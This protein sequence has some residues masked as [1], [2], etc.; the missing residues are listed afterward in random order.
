MRVSELAPRAI[1]TC[2][3]RD[4]LDR[5][6]QQMWEHDVGCLPVLDDERVVGMITDRDACMA[7]FLQGAPPR[8]IAV[9]S[10]MS[11]EVATCLESDQVLDVA[12]LM[13]QRQVRRIPVLDHAGRL[14]GLI[15]VNDLA[16]AAQHGPLASADVTSVLCSI[17]HPR[18]DHP[19]GD[20]D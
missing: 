18:V 5:A 11:R 10:V 12:R 13:R 20:A 14:R 6:I 17:T 8:S 7:T 19:A 3:V 16:R 9:S 2:S 4:G 1:V 15:T